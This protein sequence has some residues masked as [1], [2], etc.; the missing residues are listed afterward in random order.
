M[1]LLPLTEAELALK[2]KQRQICDR[3]DSLRP[4]RSLA[5]QLLD[6]FTVEELRQEVT[7]VWYDHPS[8]RAVGERVAKIRDKFERINAAKRS[9]SDN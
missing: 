5:Y 9:F 3:I 4:F 2:E 6:E 1:S 7:E 8:G